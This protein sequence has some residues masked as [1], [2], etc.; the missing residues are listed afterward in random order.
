[1]TFYESNQWPLNMF[2]FS[3]GLPKINK[4][5]VCFGAKGNSPGVFRYYGLARIVNGLLL[6]YKSG[7]IACH[8]RGASRWGCGSADLNV[9]VTD[10]YNYLIYPRKEYI[11]QHAGQVLLWMERKHGLK[12]IRPPKK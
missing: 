2:L 11:S 10:Q 3:L 5:L 4:H 6:V 9:V 1:M 7:S 12:C 8:S